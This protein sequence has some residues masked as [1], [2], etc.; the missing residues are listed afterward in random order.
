MLKKKLM[1]FFSIQTAAFYGRAVT[2][3]APAGRTRGEMAPDFS[4]YQILSNDVIQ[5]SNYILAER[6]PLQEYK[7]VFTIRKDISD[8]FY[9]K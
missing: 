8:N 3:R 1:G 9:C 7:C 2:P 6:V 5:G 4:A